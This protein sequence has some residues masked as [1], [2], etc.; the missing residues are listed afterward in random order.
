MAHVA[1]LKT[2]RTV[3]I[4]LIIIKAIWF[5]CLSLVFYKW[6][7]SS[8]EMYYVPIE[9]IEQRG[10]RRGVFSFTL[11]RVQKIR[12]TLVAWGMEAHLGH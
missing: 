2:L 11:L 12:K 5:I 8:T 3:N 10:E 4:T 6:H 1:K 7:L 9:Q